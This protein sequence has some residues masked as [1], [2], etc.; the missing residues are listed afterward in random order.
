[1][2]K[3]T[4]FV[5]SL[6]IAL[7]SFALNDN[8]DEALI[9]I[10]N[11]EISADEFISVYK[12][13]NI[14]NEAIDTKDVDE[15]LE[16][17]INFNLKVLEALELKLDTAESFI[18][19]LSSYRVQL[20]QPYLNDM[21]VTEQLIKEAFDRMQYDIR[22]SHILIEV[23]EYAL[24]E[25]TIK[26][27][28]KI[29]EIR[30]RALK[31]ESFEQ[32]A[33]R[34][35]D[36]PSAKDSPA[37]GNRPPMKGNAG[38]LGYFTVFNMVYPFETAAYNTAV[39]EISDIVRTNF[40]YH[41][42]KVTDKIP[43]LGVVNAAHIMISLP[44]NANDEKKK[45]AETKINEIYQ[46]LIDGDD[47][48][49][50]VKQFSDDK[51][52]VARDGDFPAFTVNRMLPVVIKAIADMQENDI[53]T[54]P[55]KTRYGWHVFKIN[56]ISGID[57]F[58]NLY[59]DIKNRVAKD[60]RSRISQEQVIESLKK[61]Y[62][63][64]E[65]TENIEPLYD[66]VDES[67]F[68]G[69]WEP[70]NSEELDDVLFSF[71][72][73]EFTQHDFLMFLKRTQV[74]RTPES[75]PAY[76]N[77]M[78][79]KF[80][81]ESVIAYENSILGKKYPEFEKIMKEYHDGILLFELTDKMVWSK[82]M[83]DTAGLNEF[84]NNNKE[85]YRWER[86]VDA[87]IFQCEKKRTAKK[88]RKEVRKANKKEDNFEDL[89]EKYNEESLL[90]VSKSSGLFEVDDHKALSIIDWEEGISKVVKADN[91][92]YFV[93]INDIL[94]PDYKNINEVKGMVIA[95]YQNYL[96]NKWVEELREKYDIQ[97]NES[98]LNKVK[99]EL[100]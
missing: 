34:E 28:E 8:K 57:T 94:E 99:Q 3:L 49:S 35:S 68:T 97:V 5:F 73:N 36:D 33:R 98:L 54:H 52:S 26:A 10:N 24:P 41:I 30:E 17:Y 72:E 18:N 64:N 96:E 29:A 85:K 92:Y 9:K 27:Y 95:D 16:L 48:V 80:I 37:Q 14:V 71:A 63:F 42:I 31:G 51:G 78:Y 66:F 59:P 43:A 69:Q 2:N 4:C 76:I 58:D 75:I 11:K 22:A 53:Y 15:Y 55:V 89:I 82:A 77:A 93:Y 40:G 45:E 47:F 87:D 23:P 21:E 12:K 86:R 44:A 50:L 90:N 38:D 79:E 1:M 91:V 20:A 6:F 7:N 61:D 13:N 84:F 62:N 81:N 83:N 39:G 65:K 19:E 25:D 67:V 74:K 56:D 46:R 70:K 88:L 100:N 60:M 32:L